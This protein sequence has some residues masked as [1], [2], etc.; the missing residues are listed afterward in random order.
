MEN[1]TSVQYDPRSLRR[2]LKRAVAPIVIRYLIVLLLLL[3]AFGLWSIYA[4]HEWLNRPVVH[5]T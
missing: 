5:L 1:D 4:F 3:L 2:W